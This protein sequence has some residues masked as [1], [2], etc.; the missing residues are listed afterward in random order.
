MSA[1][2][3]KLDSILKSLEAIKKENTDG[4]KYLRQKLEKLEKDAALGQE[5]V[6]QRVVKQLKE[7]RTFVFKKK[8]NEKQFLSN[9]NVK[10]QIDA[11]KK[12]LDLFEPSTEAQKEALQ[13]AK[14][15]AHQ[16]RIIFTDQ[17]EY[18]WAVVDEYEDDELV[19]DEDN[20]KRIEKAEKVVA[21]KVVKWKKGTNPQAN[22]QMQ[23][24]Q[25]RMWEQPP[26]QEQREHFPSCVDWSRPS[27]STS[28]LPRV[29]GPLWR[30]GPSEVC[31]PKVG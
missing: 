10:D 2:E 23:G 17:S 21:A 6:T 19:S 12:H 4:Q 25:Q 16:K 15:A 27:S 3:E 1:T 29:A 28:R 24:R 14:D 5:E 31:M 18:G 22:R 26:A 7:D 20:T 13:R 30:N 9:N 11:A 8:G